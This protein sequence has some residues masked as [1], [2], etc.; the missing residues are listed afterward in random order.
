MVDGLGELVPSGDADL[1]GFSVGAG[2]TRKGRNRSG[3]GSSI[4][5]CVSLSLSIKERHLRLDDRSGSVALW[6]QSW[7]HSNLPPIF[8]CFPLIDSQKSDPNLFA[9]HPN[10]RNHGRS[11]SLPHLIFSFMSS[12]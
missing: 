10:L 7:A 5:F 9:H 3:S 2:E 12:L 11:F 4:L 8:A 6:R 1:E